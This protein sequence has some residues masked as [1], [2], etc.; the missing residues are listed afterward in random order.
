MV[1]KALQ[2]LRCI[3]H[4]QLR[5]A[6]LAANQQVWSFG[7][8]PGRLRGGEAGAGP[9]Q[10]LSTLPYTITLIPQLEMV[11]AAGGNQLVVAGLTQVS[12]QNRLRIR[13]HHPI[14]TAADH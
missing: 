14:T 13:R 9:S 10:Q 6:P 12:W 7:S 5:I 11:S 1:C 8:R 2:F 3:H 4:R